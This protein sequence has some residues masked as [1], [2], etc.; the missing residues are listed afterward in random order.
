[1]DDIDKLKHLLRH[2]AEHNAGH[3]ETYLEWG[4]KAEDLGRNELSEILLD[5]AGKTT[6]MNK[7]F[8]KAESLCR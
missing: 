4:K 6:E 2:W 5:I 1:M 3:A 8:E 7:L